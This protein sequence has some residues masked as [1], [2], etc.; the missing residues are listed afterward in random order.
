M[1]ESYLILSYICLIIALQS[2]VGVGVLVLGTPLFL[3]LNYNIIEILFIL[4]PLSILTSLINLILIRVTHKKL[5]IIT[6]KGLKKFLI[7]CVPSIILGL[8]ILKYFQDYINFKILVSIVI[9]FSVIMVY[10]KNHIKFRINF[11]RISILSI[12]GV[13]HGL[14]NSGG[15]LMSLALSSENKKINARSLIT[16]FYLFLAFVQYFITIIIFKD[17][18]FFPFNIKLII[19]LIFGIIIGNIISNFLS[20]KKYK[21][22]INFLALASSIFLLL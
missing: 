7:S 4:L 14:T 22:L 6:F 1:I 13:V 2:A 5:S 9:I 10:L 15:T 12:I 3:L 16:F 20:E 8:L 17:S 11:F 21:L 18:L 19:T